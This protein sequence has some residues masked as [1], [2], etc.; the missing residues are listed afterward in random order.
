[1][2]SAAGGREEETD[3][4][5]AE[6]IRKTSIRAEGSNSKSITGSPTEKHAGEIVKDTSHRAS[7][8]SNR[9]SSLRYERQNKLFRSVAPMAQA[10]RAGWRRA[11]KKIKA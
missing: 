3:S 7:V 9:G 5:Y 2:R 4:K 1:M 11:R 10:H 6:G 8:S